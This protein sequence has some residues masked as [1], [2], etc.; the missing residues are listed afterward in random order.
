MFFCFVAAGAAVLGY[1]RQSAGVR[2]QTP[3]SLSRGGGVPGNLLYYST[4]SLKVA[5]YC[6]EADVK[7]QTQTKGLSIEE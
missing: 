3:V 5:V 6:S 1:Q 7:R 4:Y 2:R